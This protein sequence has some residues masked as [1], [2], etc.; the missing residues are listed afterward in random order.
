M[1]GLPA[2][3]SF[4]AARLVSSLRVGSKEGRDKLMMATIASMPPSLLA[5]APCT[6]VKVGLALVGRRSA[7]IAH[8]WSACAAVRDPA[9]LTAVQLEYWAGLTADCREA[10]TESLSLLKAASE[11]AEAPAA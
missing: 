1:C 7:A 4:A 8:F 10:F 3:R 5:E 9:E 6:A 11:S 2:T